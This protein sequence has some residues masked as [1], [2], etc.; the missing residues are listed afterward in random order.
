MMMYTSN[1]DFI[2]NMLYLTF[3]FIKKILEVLYGMVVQLLICTLLI[4]LHLSSTV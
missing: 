2:N 3:L 4:Y 1:Y